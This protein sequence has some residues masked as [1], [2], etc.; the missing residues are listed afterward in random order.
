MILMSHKYI[1][2]IIA[3]TKYL[4]ISKN[5]ISYLTNLSYAK[6][7]KFFYLQFYIYFY[8]LPFN[9]FSDNLVSSLDQCGST[10]NY[11]SKEKEIAGTKK[12]KKK[13]EIEREKTRYFFFF[14]SFFCLSTIG[15]H[16]SAYS[17]CCKSF[18]FIFPLSFLYF[19]YVLFSFSQI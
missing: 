14:L 2:L 12:K 10:P 9:A 17:N 13:K 8:I 15:S 19:I 16:C 11:K 7:L 6:F 4:F 3:F 1:L 18:F 5:F